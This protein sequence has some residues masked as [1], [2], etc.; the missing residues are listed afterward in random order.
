MGLTHFSILKALNPN[1][2]FTI[3]EPNRILRLIQSKNINALFLK[4]DLNI[5]DPFDISLITTPP[6]FHEKLLKA[7]I[8][9]GDN[10]IFIEKPFGG[11]TNTKFNQY[12]SDK[13]IFIGY[14]LRFNPCINWIKENISSNEIKS[15]EAQY[16]SNTIEHK[17]KGW[18]NSHYSGVLN[19]MG[20]HILDLIQ[21][22]TGSKKLVVN[23]STK[24]S[25]ISDVD[26]IV[27]ATLIC[28]K[29]IKIALHLNWVKKNI[30][31]PIFSLNIELKNKTKIFVDQQIIKMYNS[32][33]SLIK[34]ISVT[35]IAQ[36]V[37][38]YLRGVDFTLQMMDLLNESKII[39]NYSQSMYINK[40][41]KR[42]I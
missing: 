36:T 28:E 40:I 11:S 35:D 34:K 19:E 30:R 6:I 16:L 25:I 2:K 9:R 42:I 15:I 4:S 38:Y 8:D 39:S 29:N 7:C 20:S 17:P 3:I 14:V 13:N 10:K 37:P 12:Y 26:D 5:K 32:D 23:S 21:Y 22:L 27:D 18:R 31:K 41:M 33:G 24:K 1:I